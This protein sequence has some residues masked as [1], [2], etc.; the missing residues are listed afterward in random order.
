MVNSFVVVHFHMMIYS[1]R[2]IDSKRAGFLFSRL[3][4]CKIWCLPFLILVI[5]ACNKEYIYPIAAFEIYPS[6]GDTTTLFEF[7][8]QPSTDAKDLKIALKYR[9]DFENDQI[10][11]TD[12]NDEE[13][14]LYTYVLPGTYEI[15]LEVKNLDGLSTIA[16]DT[17]QV[18]GMNNEVSTL[19]DDRDGQTYKIVKIK[20]QW[21][22]A[23]SLRFGKVI[24][25][26]Q[27][28]MQDNDT[29]ECYAHIL[30]NGEDL[31]HVYSW[32]ECMRYNKD[33]RQGICP[34]GWHIPNENE[35]K[36]VYRDL[37]QE[38]AGIYLGEEGFSRLELQNGIRILWMRAQQ[39]FEPKQQYASYWSSSYY[40][41]QDQAFRVGELNFIKPNTGILYA[42]V[43]DNHLHDG[44]ET[45]YLNSIRCVK[46]D[47]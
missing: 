44:N 18:V 30:D 24:N 43:L 26:L 35:W 11:D 9:W 34:N 8:A 39:I 40:I 36:S 31:G 28:Q 16:R 19:F 27:Q 46:D 3:S 10:W 15:I 29:V 41:G 25:P 13:I 2:K 1:I 45:Q 21:W 14:S 4:F 42:H 7:N 12:F 17:I 5:S 20:D 37:I 32:Y 33:N 38:Y 23:E 22:M 6:H 47:E